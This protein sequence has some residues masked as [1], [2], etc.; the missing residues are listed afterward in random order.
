MN[1]ARGE[2]PERSLAVL[3]LAALGA[4]VRRKRRQGRLV[5]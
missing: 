4:A 5:I 2:T 3:S 1:G